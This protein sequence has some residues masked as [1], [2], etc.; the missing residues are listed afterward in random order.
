MVIL[1]LNNIV[2]IVVRIKQENIRDV[3]RTKTG[4]QEGV[5]AEWNGLCCKA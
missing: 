4:T 3:L 2:G 5:L 1:V